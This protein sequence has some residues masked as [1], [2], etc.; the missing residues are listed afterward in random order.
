MKRLNKHERDPAVVNESIRKIQE[1]VDTSAGV[2][3]IDSP[4]GTTVLTL[5][6]SEPTESHH[7]HVFDVGSTDFAAVAVKGTS[8]G[9]GGPQ[10]KL[11]HDSA[12][13]ANFD[14]VGYFQAWG[15]DSA[16]NTQCYYQ[17]Y[18]QITDVTSG[19]EDSSA[20][21][22][23]VTAGTLG[24]ALTLNGASAAIAP[25]AIPAGGTAG[26]GLLLSS[27]ANFGVF[28]GSGVPTLSAAKGSLYLRS[29]GSS[30]TTRMYVNTNGSTTWTSVTTAA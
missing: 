9:G 15:R 2:T 6:T 16:A 7:G 8:A 29:D 10:M 3:T 22:Q 30:T 19:S 14:I 11:F 1:V 28:F 4:V 17:Q 26:T 23:T 13:P 5:G 27:T 12:S 24:T 20:A 21:F 18:T 25:V